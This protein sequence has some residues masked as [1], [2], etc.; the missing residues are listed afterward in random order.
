MSLS[1]NGTWNLYY[2]PK[3]E[4]EIRQPADLTSSG[5]T[6][7]KAQVPGNVELDLIRAGELPDPF[8]GG[9]SR[10]LHPYEAYEWWYEREFDTPPGV[11]GKR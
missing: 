10:K 7:I 1:L 8:Y 2:F 6:P 11:G 4:K 3:G 5:L 9:N